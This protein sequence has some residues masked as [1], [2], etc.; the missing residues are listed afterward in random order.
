MLARLLEDAGASVRVAASGRAALDIAA[1]FAP[2]ALVCDIGMPD[3][4][5]LELRR[6]LLARG[7]TMPAVALTAYASPSDETRAHEAG[8]E[9]YLAK[10]VGARELVEV[11]AQMLE[12]AKKPT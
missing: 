6:E 7:Q 2:D 11:V 5:G 8:F 4:D 9:R 1:Q 12:D 10:P 3:M